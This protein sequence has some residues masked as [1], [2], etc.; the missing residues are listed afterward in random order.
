M[1]KKEIKTDLWV[2]DLL[3]D[4][5]LDL[6]PQGSDIAELDNALKTASKA[7]TGKAGYPE[8]CG[9]VKDFVIVIEDKADTANH[10]KHNDKDLICQNA[11]SVRDFAVNGA[12]HYGIHLAKNTSYKKIIAIGVSGNEKRHKISPL[13]INERGEYKTLED[14]ETFTLFNEKNIGEYYTKN[15][16]KEQTDEEKTTAEILKDAKELH[17]DLRNYGSIQD[18]DKPLIVSGILLALREIEYKNFD[19]DNLNGDEIKTDGQKIYEA[20]QANLDRAQVKPQVKKDKLL[21]QFLVIRDT[22]AINEINSTLG[23]TPLKHYTQ[24]IYEHIY[25][26]IK[27][28][29][30]AED[31]LGRFYGEFMSYSGGD[32]QTLGIVLTPRHIVELFCELIDLKPTDSVFDPC[33]GTAGFLI[34]AMHHMLQKTDKEAEKRKIRKEQLHGIELQPYMFTI[35]TTNMIL[36]GDGKSNLEQEDFLKQNPAQLQL[37]GCNVGMMNPPYSQGSKANPN[38]F[39]I[40]FTEHLLDSL[41]ADGKA[42]VIVPQSSMTGKSKEEQAIKENILKKH[43]LEGVITLNKNTFYGVGTN[44]C[45]AVFSTGIPHEKDKIVKFINFENDGFEVQKHIGLVETISAK[46][47][48]QHLLDV[49]FGRIEAE[50]KF[51]V[52]TTIEADDEWLHSFYYFNDEIPTEADFEKVIADYLTFEVNMITHGRGYLFGLGKDDE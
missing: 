49:W 15:I 19:I 37:K 23:K 18:K 36:R 52:E 34:A 21:S 40:S 35:A 33:C 39:E 1:A 28:I 6:C 16:L 4:A 2:Y 26:N 31:Y 41:T 50:S 44:P 5:E 22:K 8:Y 20:I 43:T 29:H 11:T 24:F 42:I 12:L 30:S 51:C 7:Q 9:V 32:G 45:I 25:K 46:D 48:K 14:V 38:L 47:K 3:K 27:Y 17:E 13:F 10:I